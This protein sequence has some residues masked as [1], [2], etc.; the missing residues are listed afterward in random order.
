VKIFTS[1]FCLKIETISK[2]RLPEGIRAKIAG[3]RHENGRKREL[4]HP[5]FVADLSEEGQ[6]F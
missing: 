2:P 6:G 1:D 4:R 5:A 3:I